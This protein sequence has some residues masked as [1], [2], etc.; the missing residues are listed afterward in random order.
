MEGQT[1]E[2]LINL[3]ADGIGR[4][5]SANNN[6]RERQLTDLF[7]DDS[8]RTA[9]TAGTDLRTLCVQI[10]DLYKQ[11]L[12]SLPGGV[13]IWSFAMR[14]KGDALNYHLVFATRHRL[15]LAKM[16]E[17][18][19]AID[20]TGSYSF[21][22][23]HAGQPLLFRDDDEELYADKLFSNF[24]GQTISMDQADDFALTETPFINAKG[25]LAVLEKKEM[26]QVEAVGGQKR[27]P[28]TYPEG[29]VA[30]LRF[31]RF[32]TRCEHPELF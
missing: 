1:A 2:L 12:K 11:R 19:K 17:A 31:G 32:A 18:M 7:G 9:L 16:K 3:D 29:K 13:L 24:D 27:R 10:L 23:A 4:I 21:S 5:F 26:L 28:N 30:A 8:W 15:G 25:I 14:G 20:Q 22:D 6:N